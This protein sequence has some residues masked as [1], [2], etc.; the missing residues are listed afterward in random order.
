MPFLMKVFVVAEKINVCFVCCVVSEN[1]RTNDVMFYNPTNTT[2]PFNTTWLLDR[3]FSSGAT[4]IVS[5]PL[6]FH[7]AHE[8]T[9]R[10]FPISSGKKN[11]YAIPSLPPS[12]FYDGRSH[13]PSFDVAVASTVVFSWR[14]P[15]P[16]SLARDGAYANLFATILSSEALICFY[17]LATDLPVIS[18]IELFAADLASY[19]AAAIADNGTV[20]VNYGRLSCDSDQ[21]G[22]GFSNDSDLF[23]RSWQSDSVFRTGQ[24][25]IVAVSTRNSIR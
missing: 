21:W 16:P 19:D 2:D 20:L 8:K 25:K 10:F 23:G 9:L 13:P 12:R 22:S 24:S 17:S 7:H 18:S 15:W 1:E 3:Y 11:C 14:S 5:E 4:G 6:N